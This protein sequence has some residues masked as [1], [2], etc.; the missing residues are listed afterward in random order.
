MLMTSGPTSYKIQNA[1]DLNAAWQRNC[2][3][4]QGI[5]A[6]VAPPDAPP[7]KCAAEPPSGSTATGLEKQNRQME[8]SI[9][10]YSN[11]LRVSRA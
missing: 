11:A 10:E 8:K 5:Y 4:Q 2:G 3:L 6:L 7:L 9:I 1:P